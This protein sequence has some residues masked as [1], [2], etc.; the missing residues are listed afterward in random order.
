MP[1]QLSQREKLFTVV[2]LASFF[3][4]GGGGYFVGKLINKP[5]PAAAPNPKVNN[6]EEVDHKGSS[7]DSKE[8]EQAITQLKEGVPDAEQALLLAQTVRSGLEETQKAVQ[9]VESLLIDEIRNQLESPN[10]D[11]SLEKKVEVLR[12]LN[13]KAPFAFEGMKSLEEIKNA[14]VA[15]KA[16]V[17]SSGEEGD[18]SEETSSSDEVVSEIQDLIDELNAEVVTIEASKASEKDEALPP[19]GIPDC[20]SN[21]FADS[22]KSRMQVKML[23]HRNWKRS[24]RLAKVQIPLI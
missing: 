7:G 23:L 12:Q 20:S 2:L 4:F 5:E 3:I 10:P 18:N 1:Q 15:L 8:F 11:E 22:M 9:S 24:S 21:I 16:L 17:G 19:K 6:G 13:P 14:Y